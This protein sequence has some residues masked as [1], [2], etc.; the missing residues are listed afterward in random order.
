MLV[1][2]NARYKKRREEFQLQTF[3]GQLEHIYWVNFPGPCAEL[4]N[5][6]PTTYI[7]AAIRNCVL[8][9]DDRELTGLDIHFISRMGNLDVIDITSVQALVGRV[10][11]MS[12]DWAIIDRSGVLAR[13]EWKGEEDS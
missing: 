9:S 12:G 11:D 8:E 6:E 10:Q 4:G 2:L 5:D 13:A 3:Y 1:D 7:L